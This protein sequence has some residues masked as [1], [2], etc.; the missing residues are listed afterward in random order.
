MN[1]YKA[2][3]YSTILSAANILTV[4]VVTK[5]TSVLIGPTG[6]AIFGQFSNVTGIINLLTVGCITSGLIKFIAQHKDDEQKM[7]LYISN[8]F[9]IVLFLSVL[10][11]LVLIIFN[12]YVSY[13]TFYTNEYRMIIVLYALVMVLASLNTF[14]DSV[15]NGLMQLKLITKINIMASFF[16]LIITS[17]LA[18][19][20]LIW[21]C[22]IAVL[23]NIIFKFT[24]YLFAFKKT[25]L[26][27]KWYFQQP[28]NKTII[29]QFLKFSTL[30]FS[31]IFYMIVVNLIRT[32]LKNKV[33]IEN[34]GLWS[35]MIKLSD[36]YIAFFTSIF[37]YYYYPKLTELQKDENLLII[38]LRK[39]FK[40]IIPLIFITTV[41]IYFCRDLVIKIFLSPKF[42]D[43]R[44]LFLPQLLGDFFLIIGWFLNVQIII[45]H[46]F[47]VYSL[48]AIISYIVYYLSTI[49]L[50]DMFKITAASW[51]FV[52]ITS[53]G[54][55]FTIC[56]N[57][58]L[59]SKLIKI[60]PQ[61]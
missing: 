2:L 37:Q 48:F 51:S 54:L 12:N 56:Y 1:F 25:K 44:E 35:G 22:L 15:M 4:I 3:S 18:Y 8:A 61:Y 7:A 60:T 14:I 11:F 50:E 30:T 47:K 21:G 5:I 28:L 27:K 26:L 45:K 49:L 39:A 24:L 55:L 38:E 42:Y 34:A 41:S 23:A 16:T 10:T 33:G 17:Y 9:K 6:T 58:V 32:K 19:K 46:K 43:M 29:I 52:I 40:R 13:Y 20:F 57:R 53:F 59:F 31:G 36:T